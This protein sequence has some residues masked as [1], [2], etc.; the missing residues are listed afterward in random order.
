MNTRNRCG[1]SELHPGSEYDD[2]ERQFLVAIDRY[3]RKHGR[4][5]PTFVEV[6]NV[7]RR[8]GWRRVGPAEAEGHHNGHG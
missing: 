4:P 2:E 7:L 6:L 1:T 8:L 3:K 5:H